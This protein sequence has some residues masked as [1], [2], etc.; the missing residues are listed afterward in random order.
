MWINDVQL[1]K[2]ATTGGIKGMGNFAG[3]LTWNGASIT[4]ATPA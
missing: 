3:M 1:L 2:D 4:V